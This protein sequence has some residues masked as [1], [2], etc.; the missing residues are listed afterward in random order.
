[1]AR[2]FNPADS[3]YNEVASRIVEFRNKHPE[4]SLQ[5]ADPANPFEVKTIGDKTFVVYVAAAY[6]TPDD[7]RP[8]IGIAWEP[9]PGTTPY[10]RN[11]ELMNAE[12]SAWGRAIVAVGAADS[13]RGVASANEVRN[14][15][16]E[17]DEP[18]A[19]R[20]QST[21]HE[22]L[23][24]IEKRIGTAKSTGE[25]E[26]LAN[27]VRARRA[28]GRCEDVHQEHLWAL[29]TRRETELANGGTP[30]NKDGSI[31]RSRMTDEELA[32]GGHMT[33]AQLKEHNKLRREGEPPRGS[34][35]RLA[36]TPADDPWMTPAEG[37]EPR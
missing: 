22:W 31:S 16:A 9:F 28:A 3:G 12:T 23:S 33:S 17:R 7:A 2:D 24:S 1:M 6:R 27:E 25:L 32:A 13:K 4:G 14:R 37:G 8:G 21:D 11:S 34:V 10:T 30:R 35:E 15:Q 36:E 20:Q 26:M 18:E 29:G 19:P 5:P